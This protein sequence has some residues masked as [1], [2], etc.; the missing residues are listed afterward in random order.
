MTRRGHR[1]GRK[2]NSSANPARIR[3]LRRTNVADARVLARE[4]G[5]RCPYTGEFIG[6]GIGD[7]GSTPAEG[8][9]GISYSPGGTAVPATTPA[10]V[11]ARPPVV[12][13]VD[14]VID[15]QI[16]DRAYARVHA[17]SATATRILQDLVNERFNLCA[18]TKRVNLAKQ[19]GVGVALEE[20]A[21]VQWRHAEALAQ[22]AWEALRGFEA[23]I[24]ELCDSMITLSDKLSVDLG[25]WLDEV[26]ETL[27]EIHGPLAP[28]SPASQASPPSTVCVTPSDDGMADDLCEPMSAMASVYG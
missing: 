24:A 4:Q 25:I 7:W 17:V 27:L 1:V 13:E 21:R 26:R 2:G 22:R 6:I 18:V 20:R 15:I 10:P 12:L 23:A 28:A 9:A 3:T 5:Y 19:A 8:A 14:H 16:C 11:G